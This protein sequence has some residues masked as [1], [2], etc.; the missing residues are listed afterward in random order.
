MPE[1]RMDAAFLVCNAA[2]AESAANEIAASNAAD[3]LL[4][5]VIYQPC[6]SAMSSGGKAAPPYWI[7]EFERQSSSLPDPL[8]GWSSSADTLGQVRLKFPSREAAIAHA[9]RHGIAA[10]VIEPRRPR[11]T[12]HTY[13]SN[14]IGERAVGVSGRV[15]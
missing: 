13:A 14:F 2:T 10:T 6:R 15:T 11:P 8:M 7:L 5:G 12:I 9:R 1:G 4:R 3:P